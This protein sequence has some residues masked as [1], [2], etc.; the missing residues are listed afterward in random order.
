M[1]TP[2]NDI[3]S[4]NGLNT[5]IFNNPYAKLCFNVMLT[6]QYRKI[7]YIDLDTTFTAYVKAGLLPKNT[8]NAFNLIKIYLA[9]EGRFE[10]M[11]RDII[12][13]MSD[14]SIVIFDSINSFYN[15]Y[16]K[17]IDIESGR[18]I[19][20]LNHLLSI[21]LMMLL[22]NGKPLNV[23]IL[24]TSMIRYKK[25]TEWIQSPASKRLLQKKSIVKLNVEMMNGDLSVEILT[26]PVL[27]SKTII[28]R[29]QGVKV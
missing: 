26:H 2:N 10:S 19:S 15:M 20:N 8:K 16:Y 28:F 21:F 17:K 25:E 4:T 7:I 13:S 22:K 9:N 12:D 18:G 5:L 27:A 23:P 24:V 3:L 1:E 6:S 29:N 14:S 11:L